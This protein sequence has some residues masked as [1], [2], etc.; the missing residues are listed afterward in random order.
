MAR[1]LIFLLLI[2]MAPFALCQQN[3]PA[4]PL[5]EPEKRTVL[6]QLY[7]LQ[8]A[9][10]QIQ[11]YDQFIQRE[12][13]QDQKERD[14]WAR[15]LEL[16]NQATALARQEADLEKERADLYKGLYDTVRKKKAGFG[17]VVKRIFTLGLSRCG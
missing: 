11:T 8:T 6:L 9:R 10:A 15:A 7:E 12:K 5:T 17:C 4:P 1:L 3:S 2:S 13:D 14:N 16:E